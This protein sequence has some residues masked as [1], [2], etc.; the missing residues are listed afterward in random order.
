MMEQNTFSKHQFH[1]FEKVLVRDTDEEKWRYEIL[2]HIAV[3]GEYQTLGF[4]WK[5]CI[6]FEGNEHLLDTKNKPNQ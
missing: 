3:G 1:Q 5:Q 2:S 4:A 6:P